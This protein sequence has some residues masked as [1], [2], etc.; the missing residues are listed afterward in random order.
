MYTY[1]HIYIG[2]GIYRFSGIL[3]KYHVEIPGFNWKRNEMSRI[4]KKKEKII[5]N[6][7]KSSKSS[8]LTLEFAMDVTQFHG[9]CMGKALFC[10]EF[11]SVKWEI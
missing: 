1:I 2:H 5:L 11:P 9:I 4:G 7:H 8:F 6:F 10:P 3:K